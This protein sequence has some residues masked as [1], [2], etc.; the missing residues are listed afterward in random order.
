MQTSE[1]KLYIDNI[2]RRV[3]TARL[4]VSDYHIVKIV[5]VSKSST[6]DDIA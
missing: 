6:A 3:E 1:Y 2:I 5:A 4:K